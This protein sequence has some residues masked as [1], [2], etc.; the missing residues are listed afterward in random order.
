MADEKKPIQLEHSGSAVVREMDDYRAHMLD[1]LFGVLPSARTAEKELINKNFATPE[2]ERSEPHSPLLQK[3]AS[4]HLC[5]QPT[6]TESVHAV[7]RRP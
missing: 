1:D 7:L 6:L 3:R 4:K 2:G 5:D